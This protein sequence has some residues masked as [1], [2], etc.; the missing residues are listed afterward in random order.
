MIST[1]PQWLLNQNQIHSLTL[2]YLTYIMTIT[3]VMVI[4]FVPSQVNI[5][6]SLTK[7][8]YCRLK[9]KLLAKYLSQFPYFSSLFPLLKS[10]SFLSFSL[11]SYIASRSS[12]YHYSVLELNVISILDVTVEE[13]PHVTWFLLLGT[14]LCHSAAPL[15]EVR[16]MLIF[17]HTHMLQSISQP[18]VK[19]INQNKLFD[20]WI[21]TL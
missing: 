19:V 9:N 12:W 16:R 21:R 1:I 2:E 20:E 3:T 8:R 7:Q 15:H 6:H 5:R 10:D 14:N 11:K 4:L 18:I 17:N 13:I